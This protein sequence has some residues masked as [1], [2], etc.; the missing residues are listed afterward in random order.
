MCIYY[1]GMDD[2][3]EECGKTQ[4]IPSNYLANEANEEGEGSVP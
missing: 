4:L 1:E 3:L 2:K